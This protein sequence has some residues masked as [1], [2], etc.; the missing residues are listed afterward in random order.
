MFG[1][2]LYLKKILILDNTIENSVLHEYFLK[3]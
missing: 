1:G 2:K 3:M